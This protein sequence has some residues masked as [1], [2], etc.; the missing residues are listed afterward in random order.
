MHYGISSSINHDGNSKTRR[1]ILL[2]FK[3][4]SFLIIHIF[5]NSKLK[6]S[7]ENCMHVNVVEIEI[8]K[9]QI[10]KK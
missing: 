8:C 9:Q 7:Y 1:I 2:S 4:V 5:N 6:V 3:T 10:K